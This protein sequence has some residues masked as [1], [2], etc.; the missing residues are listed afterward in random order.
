MD[1]SGLTDDSREWAAQPEPLPRLPLWTSIPVWNRAGRQP[2]TLGSQGPNS[3]SCST[4]ERQTQRVGGEV[5]QLHHP[6]E[7]LTS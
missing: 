7:T 1:S 4:E 2:P 3:P 6:Q 5:S